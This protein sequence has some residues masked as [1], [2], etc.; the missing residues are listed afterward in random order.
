SYI[1]M[2]DDA[3]KILRVIGEFDGVLPFNDKAA[4]EV[5]DREFGMSKAA[6]KR[7]VGKLYKER[8]IEIGEKSIRLTEK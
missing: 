4:P 5:I 3:E 8:K 1:K 6:F 7:A 2:E